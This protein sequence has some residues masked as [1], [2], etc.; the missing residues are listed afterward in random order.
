[1]LVSALE[2]TRGSPVFTLVSVTKSDGAERLRI[3]S[4]STCASI[5]SRK[6]WMPSGLAW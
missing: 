6:G 1:M 3:A 2:I 5:A 4:M